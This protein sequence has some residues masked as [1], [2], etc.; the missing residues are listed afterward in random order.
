MLKKTSPPITAKMMRISIM[1]IVITKYF[2]LQ[3][4]LFFKTL[5]LNLVTNYIKSPDGIERSI[6]P[7]RKLLLYSF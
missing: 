7:K 4:P 6:L 2:I 3:L 1:I 5:T